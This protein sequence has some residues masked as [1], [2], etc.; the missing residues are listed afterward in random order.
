MTENQ[1]SGLL[2]KAER[3]QKWSCRVTRCRGEILGS[4]RSLICSIV[5]VFGLFS[6]MCAKIGAMHADE[7][8]RSFVPE[9]LTHT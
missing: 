4:H 8:A 7:T 2:D 1:R 3:F 9:P 5:D 6:G